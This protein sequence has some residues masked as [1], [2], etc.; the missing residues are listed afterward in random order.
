M[1]LNLEM[2]LCLC[3]LCLNTR[4]LFDS[5]MLEEKKSGDEI[6]KSVTEFFTAKCD[7]RLSS[8]GFHKWACVTEK[9]KHCSK[10]KRIL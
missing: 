5:T 9:C 1:P 4:L 6:F 7:C 10:V 2:A 3:K 8:N